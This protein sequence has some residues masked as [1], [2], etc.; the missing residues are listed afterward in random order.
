MTLELTFLGAPR[1]VR[2][3]E[4]VE[5]DTRKAVALLAYLAV[6]ARPHTRDALC[7]LLWPESDHEHARA[8]L[9]RT[10]STLRK[11][12]GDEWVEAER[13]RVDLR[14][15]PSLRVDVAEFR[16]GIAAEEPER[17]AAA[18]GLYGG[19]F[20]AGFTLRDSVAFDDWQYFETDALR[21]ELAAGLDRLIDFHAGLGELDAAVILARR[22][23]ALNPLDEPAHRRLIE[24]FARKGERAAAVRQYRTC[25]RVL[26]AELG[27]AP[28][29][30][31]TSLYRAIQEN[32]L[33]P[34]AASPGPRSAATDVRA[35]TPLVGRETEL[36]SLRDFHARIETDGRLAV[37]EGELGIGKSRLLEELLVSLRE[38]GATTIALRCHQDERVLA[39]APVAEAMQRALALLGE[40]PHDAAPEL[41]R[42]LPEAGPPTVTPLDSSG[43]Q[44]RFFEALS[45][46][47]ASAL[48]GRV[49]GVLA[50]D[51]VHDAD[52][53]S[54]DFLAYLVR[55]LR[56]RPVL[57]Q[58]T[59]R[60]DEVDAGHR[61]RRLLADA[62]RSETALL[63][64][65]RRLDVSEVNELATALTGGGVAIPDTLHD[66]TGGLPLFVV[67]YSRA[68]RRGD[69]ESPPTSVRELLRAR[70]ASVSDVSAQ[71][72]TAAAV[73]GPEF[74]A[75]MLR[76][77]GGRTDEET[78][79]AVEELASRGLIREAGGRYRFEHE[80]LRLLAYD[81]ASLARRRLLHGR[82]ADGLARSARAGR[83][84]GQIARHYELAGR[85]EEAAA[86]YFEAAARARSV[87]ANAEAVAHLEAALALGHPNPGT[88]H[89][90]LGDLQTLLGN[91]GA[92][93]A[94]Y[95]AAAAQP[96]AGRGPAVEHKLGGLHARRGEWEL[97]ATHLG[98]ALAAVAADDRALRARVLADASLVAQRRGNGAEA[99]TI[100]RRA[101]L[102]AEEAGD[103]AALAQAHN[104]LGILMRAS[105]PA[106]AREHLERSLR[107]ADE[108]GDPE[109]RVAALNNLA[110]LDRLEGDLAAAVIRTRNA[111]EL[112]ERYGDRHR[113]AALH[114]NLADLLHADDRGDEAMVHLKA[115]VRL[116]SEVGERGEPQPEIWKLVEW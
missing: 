93:L 100:A 103:D 50:F 96:A 75:D 11:G 54:L 20:L 38:A 10:L 69:A 76:E 35:G 72:L 8:A 106:G 104:I 56:D 89:E 7:S 116:F 112:C 21:R 97:A 114:N 83:L 1:I 113:E 67:E 37:I 32:R 36:A 44:T 14:R 24:L 48:A 39:Y 9:R 40:A 29:E 18:V 61:L 16:S 12:L 80:Q 70:I 78:V 77:V 62:L 51:D 25:V 88:V 30:E 87:Y 92:A 33:A 41:G 108:R 17:V 102:E 28:V 43:A 52:A 55:R 26:R 85:E 46:V 105:D 81:D 95:E 19:D 109:A 42:L 15:R 13:D 23:L 64:K 5:V 57:V 22:R 63:I 91:Y 31:T 86:C 94:S 90:A 110:A 59:W 65:P 68:L 107:W 45:T 3:G 4:P 6:T 47:L 73:L 49:A 2:D 34:A 99:F 115:A 101:L 58:L 66:E 27:V 53:S 84:A 98:A 74:D 60:T 79:A 111:L 71:V 82:F